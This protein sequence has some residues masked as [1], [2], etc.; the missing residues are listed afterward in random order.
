VD[1]ELLCRWLHEVERWP[2][3]TAHELLRDYDFSLSLLTHYEE[4]R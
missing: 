2:E 3:E 4:S 1:S